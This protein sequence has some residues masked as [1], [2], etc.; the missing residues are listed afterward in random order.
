MATEIIN[1]IDANK[2]KINQLQVADVA[3]CFNGIH[4][5]VKLN[6][7][8]HNKEYKIVST[9]VSTNGFVEINP[10]VYTFKNDT[11]VSIIISDIYIRTQSDRYFI[12]NLTLKDN[13]DNELDTDSVIIDCLSVASLLT[14]T[15]TYTNTTTPTVTPT[16]TNTPTYTA[17]ATTTPTVTP[18]ITGTSELLFNSLYQL[19]DTPDFLC[20]L[21]PEE[22]IYSLDN[23]PLVQILCNNDENLFQLELTNLIVGNKYTYNFSIYLPRHQSSVKMSPRTDTFVASETNKN[24]ETVI[25]YTRTD[26][27]ILKFEFQNDTTSE[28]QTQF[29]ILTCKQE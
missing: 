27:L 11:A 26:L 2:N 7:L 1:I 25:R 6:G 18:T 19:A 10:Q 14:P 28:K 4:L 5:N 13:Q 23:E 29:F 24:I 9:Q 22:L 8:Q 21:Y 20:Q 15:P 16:V 17:T 3:E 12:V